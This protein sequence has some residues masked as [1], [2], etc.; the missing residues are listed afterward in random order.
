MPRLL[1]CA[2]LVTLASL[3]CGGDDGGGPTPVPTQITDAQAAIAET[4]STMSDIESYHMDIE[5][6][7]FGAPVAYFV[8]Y[9]GGDY[10]ERLPADLSS[11]GIELY[12]VGEYQFRRDCPA[13]GSCT[14]WVRARGRRAVPNF[15]GEA[16]SGPETL[17][18]VAAELGEGWQIAQQTA[19]AT[20]LTGQVNLGDAIRENQER[21]FRATGLSE[22]EIAA[23]MQA[24]SAEGLDDPSPS[25]ITVTISGGVITHVSVAVP[26]QDDNPHIETAYSQFGSIDLKAPEDY[27]DVQ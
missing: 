6:S 10:F 21:N 1:L 7:P 22:E 18:L 12:Y 13:A 15:S 26:G 24:L 20:V 16:N 23:A 25:A 27:V 9:D 17:P 14:P 19:D 5:L 2:L 11:G 4:L 3:A 8:D